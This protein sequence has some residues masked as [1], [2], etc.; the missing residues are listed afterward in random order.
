MGAMMGA[1]MGAR[2]AL[3]AGRGGARRGDRKWREG[4]RLRWR[5]GFLAVLG[6]ATAGGG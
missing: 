4:Q 3:V 1:M 2:G 5:K 6:D